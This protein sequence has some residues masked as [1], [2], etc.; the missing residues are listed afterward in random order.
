MAYEDCLVHIQFI[1]KVHHITCVPIETRVFLWIIKAGADICREN[2]VKNH[3]LKATS[4]IRYEVVPNTL[5]CTITMSQFRASK[6][7]PP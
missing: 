3:H 4:K 2:Q 6:V 5:V 7:P 1:K